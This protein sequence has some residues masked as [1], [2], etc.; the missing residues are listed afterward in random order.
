MGTGASTSAASK[1]SPRG[2]KAT[3]SGKAAVGKIVA[4]K[5]AAG[6]IAASKTA[7][8][9]KATQSIKPKATV[10]SSFAA[11]F[12]SE[13][14]LQAQ[15]SDEAARSLF[16]SIDVAKTGM[17][18]EGMISAA[19]KERGGA[20]QDEW[21][22]VAIHDAVTVFDSNC[23]GSLDLSEFMDAMADLRAHNGKLDQGL[24]HLRAVAKA[25]AKAA[26]D[27]GVKEGGVWDRG[28]TAKMIRSFNDEGGYWSDFGSKVVQ[29][30][31][32]VTGSDDKK[33]GA[34][35]AQF[36][37]WYPK[38]LAE[39]EQI[40]AD[41]AV[42]AARAEAQRAEAKATEF[43]ADKAEWSISMKRLPEAVD[44]AWAM[45]KV[46]LLVDMTTLEGDDKN[47]SFSPLENFYSYSGD[48]L[49][50][51]KKAIVEARALRP[52]SSTAPWQICPQAFSAAVH[53]GE[54]PTGRVAR[55][56]RHIY[57]ST[58]PP[59]RHSSH[60]R[61]L[62]AARVAW[63]RRCVVA[64]LSV[65]KMK[66][67]DELHDEFA[68]KLL[69]GLKQ[70]RSLVLLCSN[71]S[72]PLKSTFCTSARFP[73]EILNASRLKAAMAAERLEDTMLSGLVQWMREAGIHKDP[74]YNLIVPNDK[75]R[76]VLV[77]KFAPEDYRG[78]LQ[79]QLPLDEL[80]AVRVT[81]E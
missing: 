41:W 23:D 77:T 15:A 60:G 31:A 29:A 63:C 65:K 54:S 59:R 48:V 19:V 28:C 75:F 14:L 12:A 61:S 39:L 18:S 21:T 52:C 1:Q 73:F 44:A 71:S 6:K 20:L 72:P 62:T 38:L 8:N 69:L 64:Q 10:N 25:N 76:L 22:E 46:P 74:S 56:H 57:F 79:N 4:G 78:F 32:E 47:S 53:P 34:T 2:G 27:T 51:T 35:L 24:L 81:T 33:A 3:S 43:A 16:E 66:T 40:R 9:I 55:A 17:I 50:E 7:P 45:G 68:K 36:L 80:Q 42:E 70:G 11:A 5:A 26:Y 67:L 37:L 49:L 58:W 13:L 30:H